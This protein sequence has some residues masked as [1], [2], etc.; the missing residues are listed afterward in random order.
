MAS[1]AERQARA[2]GAALVRR[3]HRVHLVTREVAGYPT[4]EVVEG[5]EVHRWVRTSTRGPLFGLS[6]VAGV[7]RALR[8]LRP[9]YDLIHTYQGLWEAI[10]TGF[11]RFAFKGAPVLIEP[12]CSGF[13]GEAQ[14]VGRTRGAPAL[15]ALMRNN[16]AFAAISAEI[17]REWLALGIPPSKLLRVVNGVDADHFRPGPPSPEVLAKLPDGFRVAFTGR[18]HPQK[19]LDLLLDAWPILA[20]RTPAQ[21]VLIGQGGERDRLRDRAGELGVADRIHF[22]GSVDDPADWL[23]ASHA[24][25]LPSVAE[26]MSNSLLEAM[27]TALPCLASNIGGNTDLLDHERS[28]LLLPLGDPAAWSSAIV[29]VVGDS[30]FA[31]GL[32]QSAR[33]RIEG[34][35]ALSVTVDRLEALY[36]RLLA[37]QSPHPPSANEPIAATMDRGS[38]G[39]D[40][41]KAR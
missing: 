21:L 2:Q 33:R 15:R 1:G 34:D 5:I 36:R 14:E 11:G 19:N 20:S 8:R 32:G 18:L 23:R 24:F 7:T 25:A 41:S 30:T 40:A 13:F 27:A 31:D 29:R 4:D 17:E 39:A 35:Y 28:G 12:A 16:T 6:F 26:G 3:G 22:V 37:G 38:P 10:S 9:D